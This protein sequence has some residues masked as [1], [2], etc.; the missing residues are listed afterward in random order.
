MDLEK[1]LTRNSTGDCK[2]STGGSPGGGQEL[3]LEALKVGR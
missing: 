1:P 2:G 3:F